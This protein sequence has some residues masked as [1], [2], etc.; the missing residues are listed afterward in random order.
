MI[1][2]RSREYLYRKSTKNASLL[3]N[4]PLQELPGRV[5]YLSRFFF[6]E[7]SSITRAYNRIVVEHDFDFAEDKSQFVYVSFEDRDGVLSLSEGFG[8]RQDLPLWSRFCGYQKQFH[9]LSLSH[10]LSLSVFSSS[11]ASILHRSFVLLPRA[12]RLFYC[13]FAL[14]VI[15]KNFWRWIVPRDGN[16]GPTLPAAFTQ[17]TGE[18]T[19]PVGPCH[20]SLFGSQSGREIILRTVATFCDESARVSSHEFG[21]SN[22]E[23]MLGKATDKRVFNFFFQ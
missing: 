19:F 18:T 7:S 1:I 6:S 15:S 22:C 10:L 16:R 12:C 17:T 20:G 2:I 23:I 13:A 9:G 14:E 21:L 4:F 8:R 11:S 3:R 5:S